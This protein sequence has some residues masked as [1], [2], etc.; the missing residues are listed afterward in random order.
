MKFTKEQVVLFQ[1]LSGDRNPLHVDPDYARRTQ[2]GQPVVYG[3]CGVI[4]AL[5][6]WADGRAF[7]LRSIAAD[8]R[9]PLYLDTEYRTETIEQAGVVT[10]KYWRGDTL[11]AKI[12]FVPELL[13]ARQDDTYKPSGFVARAEPA[14]S[15]ATSYHAERVAYTFDTS[16][17]RRMGSVLGLE[18]GQLSH[19]QLNA[20][21]WSSYQVG[22]EYP[23]KQALFSE[24]KIKFDENPTCDEFVL[25]KVTGT[26]DDRMNEVT[27]AAKGSGVESLSLRAFRRPRKVDYGIGDVA[28]ALTGTSARF[29]GKTVLVTGANR[30]FGA[31]LAKAFALQGAHVLINCR[32]SGISE[33]MDVRSQIEEAGARATLVTG[34]VASEKDC[35]DMVARIAAAN[36]GLDYLIHNAVPNFDLQAFLKHAPAD[37]E[38]S[39]SRVLAMTSHLTRECLPRLLPGA[40]IIAISSCTTKIPVPNFTHYISAKCAVEG[41][42]RG[43]S[44]EFQKLTFVIA[45]PPRM[46]T[47]QTNFAFDRN[48]PE[49]ATDVAARLL[50]RLSRLDGNLNFHEID[51]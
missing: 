26:F 50:D 27:I 37:L 39:V 45:R 19:G 44:T 42:V 21:L 49:Q 23:G 7:R 5:G 2:F 33:A 48:K 1:R 11:Q 29:D 10:A 16:A 30:G 13:D 47:D 32:E 36:P 9:K 3:I 12:T 28:G 8:F 43:L 40:R 38:Q 15:L 51:L 6:Q 41:L 24:L 14:D 46:L 18:F 17:S 35:H 20:I 22:M 25:E 34:D 4:V 31:V